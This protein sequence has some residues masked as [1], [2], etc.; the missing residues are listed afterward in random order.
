[1]HFPRGSLFFA[2]IHFESAFPGLTA[3]IICVEFAEVSQ[4]NPPINPKRFTCIIQ[5]RLAKVSQNDS[6]ALYFIVHAD[7]A[8]GERPDLC[9]RNLNMRRVNR[10]PFERCLILKC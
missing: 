6:D 7:T 1:M 5:N 9:V 3:D 2:N 10:V 8:C 4:T